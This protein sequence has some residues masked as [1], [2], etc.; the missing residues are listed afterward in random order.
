MFGKTNKIF[1]INLK[2]KTLSVE[3]HNKTYAIGFQNPLTARKILHSIEPTP[4]IVLL[5]DNTIN[6]KQDLQEVGY[7]I[8]IF[9]DTTA[10]LFIP[11]LKKGV[12]YL[13]PMND[14]G[15]HLHSY[16]VNEFIEIPIFKNIGIVLPYDI[17]DEDENEFTIRSCVVEPCGYKTKYD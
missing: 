7:D 3:N 17:I 12:P 5:R 14:I 10:T 4:K 15:Y 9:I 1:T 6:L 11:K 13:D 2:N 8:N 16:E